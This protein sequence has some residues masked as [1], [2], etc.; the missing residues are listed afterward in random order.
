MMFQRS[1]PGV[2]L[3]YATR[4]LTTGFR[5]LHMPQLSPTTK[6]AAIEEWYLKEGKEVSSYDLAMRVKTDGLVCSENKLGNNSGALTVE[7]T[8]LD[9]EI[10]E[11]G[12]VAKILVEAEKGTYL[13]VGTPLA[14]VS[15]E[16]LSERDLDD[17]DLEA[18][19]ARNAN[20][21]LW[22]AY[23]VD[24]RDACRTCD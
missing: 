13:K 20:R 1:I 7:S 10:I 16:Y 18:I 24:E 19:I 8:S 5:V 12:I 14:I 23:L 22:Q 9:V 3:Q 15:T 11:D 4:T 2:A 6:S 21:A 17:L